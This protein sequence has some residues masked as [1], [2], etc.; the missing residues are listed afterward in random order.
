MKRLESTVTQKGQVTIPI[1]VRQQLG[2]KPRDRVEF[3]VEG[4]TVRLRVAMSSLLD[5]YGAVKPRRKP[6]DFGALREEFEDQV[7]VD[8]AGEGDPSCRRDS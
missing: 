2:L 6:E 5:G 8:V 3:E 7:A 4:S 1:E